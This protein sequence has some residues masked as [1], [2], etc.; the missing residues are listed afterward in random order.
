VTFLPGFVCVSPLVS[1]NSED[2]ISL[3]IMLDSMFPLTREKEWIYSTHIT[4]GNCLTNIL[5]HTL[6]DRL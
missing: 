5:M 1:E 2:K 4:S 6:D 3:S